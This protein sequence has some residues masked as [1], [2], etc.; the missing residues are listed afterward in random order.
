MSFCV[1]YSAVGFQALPGY[2]EDSSPISSSLIHDSYSI[3][4]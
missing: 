1:I 3:S 4:T 2:E